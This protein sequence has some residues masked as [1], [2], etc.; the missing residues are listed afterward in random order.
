MISIG[1]ALA[2]YGELLFEPFGFTCQVLAVAVSIHS[3]WS[4]GLRNRWEGARLSGGVSVEAAL[5]RAEADL[6]SSRPFY[7]SS[8]REFSNVFEH[9]LQTR[10]TSKLTLSFLSFLQPTRHDPRFVSLSIS[11]SSPPPSFPFTHASYFFLASHSPPPRTQ[12][13]SSGLPLLLLS[14]LRHHQRLHLAL[15]RGTRALLRHLP[16]RTFHPRRQRFRCVLP[17]R[18]CRVPHWS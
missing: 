15:H 9:Y 2:A 18:C 1:C 3:F 5:K 6:S 8:L 11:S 17:Q 12:D 4:L 7:S 10:R 14:R 16:S 13:G